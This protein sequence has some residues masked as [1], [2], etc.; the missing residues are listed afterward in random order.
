M[1]FLVPFVIPKKVHDFFWPLRNVL[2]QKHFRHSRHKICQ[3]G[4]MLQFGHTP[5]IPDIG[6]NV[7]QNSR[8]RIW[9]R[10]APLVRKR[11]LVFLSS[12]V[13]TYSCCLN[14]RYWN[15]WRTII[16]FIDLMIYYFCCQ[17]NYADNKK[18]SYHPNYKMNTSRQFIFFHFISFL[19]GGGRSP[20]P[21]C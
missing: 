11:F 3:F 8:F 4:K 14:T 13:A 19:S 15:F 12:P 9:P 5:I 2:R 1:I 6:D 10:P 20:H 17:R 7:Y 16:N 18:R 21:R